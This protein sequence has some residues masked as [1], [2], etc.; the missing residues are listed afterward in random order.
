[1]NLYVEGSL[2]LGKDLLK[3]AA[4][5]VCM[6][7]SIIFTLYLICEPGHRLISNSIITNY[8][9]NVLT[10]D[11]A[12]KIGQ[13]NLDWSASFVPLRPPFVPR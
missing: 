10:T 6:E 4:M 12:L 7:P 13:E 1:M 3:L 2:P 9:R 5:E 11:K 8:L